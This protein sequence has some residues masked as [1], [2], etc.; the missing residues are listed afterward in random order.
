[1]RLNG[2]LQVKD[3]LKEEVSVTMT[4]GELLM[5]NSMSG[6]S[7]SHRVAEKIKEV[8]SNHSEFA[9]EVVMKQLNSDLFKTTKKIL[10]DLKVVDED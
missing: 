7:N 1:M 4:V 5:I 3:I 8:H 9:R 6:T 2:E 10:V